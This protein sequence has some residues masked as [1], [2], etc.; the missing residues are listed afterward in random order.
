M[1]E[2]ELRTLQQRYEALVKTNGKLSTNNDE[3]Q[4]EVTT[5]KQKCHSYDAEI[6]DLKMKEAKLKAQLDEATKTCEELSRLRVVIANMQKRVDNA[7]KDLELKDEVIEQLKHE[8]E[9]LR[10]DCDAYSREVE[11]YKVSLQSTAREN[12]RL[13]EDLKAAKREIINYENS[14]RKLEEEIVHH[15]EEI[16]TYQGR[17]QKL[18]QTIQ[19]HKN[20]V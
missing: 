17:V 15:K 3:I 14:T 10:R 12:D 13:N 2:R 5:L 18:T 1:T 20:Q 6:K 7:F 9:D 11:S 4:H 19:K 8:K 16:G